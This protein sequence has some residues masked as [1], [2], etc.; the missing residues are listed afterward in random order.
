MR[1]PRGEA[2]ARPGLSTGRYGFDWVCLNLVGPLAHRY[3]IRCR[4][5]RTGFASTLYRS[6][7]GFGG[8]GDVAAYAFGGFAG[9]KGRSGDDGEQDQAG[10]G[11]GTS[12]FVS[13]THILCR[14]SGQTRDLHQPFVNCPRLSNPSYLPQLSRPQAAAKRA[15]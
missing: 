6:I 15:V 9:G 10:A 14:P 11:H 12:V 4:A 13:R 2:R 8:S 1:P 3:A 7:Y 5:T